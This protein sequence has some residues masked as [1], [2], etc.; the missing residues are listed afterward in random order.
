[1]KLFLLRYRGRELERF[2]FSLG[3]LSVAGCPHVLALTSTC[4]HAS[5]QETFVFSPNIGRIPQIAAIRED[6]NA[7]FEP[8]FQK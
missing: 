5:E 7:A 2:H 8:D 6:G 1:M 3:N 4:Q